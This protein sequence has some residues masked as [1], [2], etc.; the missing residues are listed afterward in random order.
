MGRLYL[1][2]FVHVDPMKTTSPLG[3]ARTKLRRR[4]TTV[5]I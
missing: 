1:A 2:L 3:M 5:V 4:I